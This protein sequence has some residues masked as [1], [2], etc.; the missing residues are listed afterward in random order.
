MTPREHFHFSARETYSVSTFLRIAPMTIVLILFASPAFAQEGGRALI[1][2]SG[3][4]GAGLA[5]LGG[6]WGIGRLTSAAVE[7]MAR[8]PQIAGNAFLSLIIAAAMIEG[9]TLF[10]IVVCM[11]QN[12]W[13]AG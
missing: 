10:A 7:S 3:A 4:F 11:G 5:V 2:F 8:Q 9:A 12:P 13:P 1:E 6:A